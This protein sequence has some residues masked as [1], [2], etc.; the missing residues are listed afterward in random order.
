MVNLM[1]FCGEW[2]SQSY[3]YSKRLDGLVMRKV[4]LFA[5][6]DRDWP[7][8]GVNCGAQPHESVGSHHPRKESSEM[9]ALWTS[10]RLLTCGYLMGVK[11][12][13]G[14]WRGVRRSND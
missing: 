6:N 1:V 14:E 5:C 8:A 2:N 10:H 12:D 9:A 7:M 11:G 13:V 3:G 4:P